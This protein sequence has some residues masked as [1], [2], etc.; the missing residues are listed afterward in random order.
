MSR[1]YL[2]PDE[3][4]QEDWNSVDAEVNRVVRNKQ[5]Y[6]RW[7]DLKRRGLTVEQIG[8]VMEPEFG[9]TLS[10]MTELMYTRKYFPVAL[11]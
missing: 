6:L 1:V 2:V 11:H 8:A 9:I 3:I 10:M 7:F 5:I 4:G